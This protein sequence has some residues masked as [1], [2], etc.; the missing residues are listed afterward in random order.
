MTKPRFTASTQGPDTPLAIPGSADGA[1]S[2]TILG[3][4]RSPAD[5]LFLSH[6]GMGEEGMI[7]EYMDF[8][9]D[10]EE[11]EEENG[12]K[13]KGISEEGRDFDIGAVMCSYLVVMLSSFLQVKN[14]GDD[15][16]ENQDMLSMPYHTPKTSDRGLPSP[17]TPPSFSSSD[18]VSNTS[19]LLRRVPPLIFLAEALHLPLMALEQCVR[20]RVSSPALRWHLLQW[21][22]SFSREREDAEC[23]HPFLR[24]RR[25]ECDGARRHPARPAEAGDHR[26]STSI[27]DPSRRE[28][29]EGGNTLYD[30]TTRCEG[31][32]PTPRATST[33]NESS[34]GHRCAS[35]HRH[36]STGTTTMGG[37][38]TLPLP[39]SSTVLAPV[40]IST[41]SRSTAPEPPTCS[42]CTSFVAGQEDDAGEESLWIPTSWVARLEA[43]V[44]YDR[45]H[46]LPTGCGSDGNVWKRTSAVYYPPPLPHDKKKSLQEEEESMERKAP[47]QNG[48]EGRPTT[49][50]GAERE[51][52]HRMKG[53]EEG[54]KEGHGSHALHYPPPLHAHDMTLPPQKAG[55]PPH[56]SLMTRPPLGTF[57]SS[58]GP[59]SRTE[60]EGRRRT[61]RRR[62]GPRGAETMVSHNRHEEFH[63]PPASSSD[64]F[65]PATVE[66]EREEEDEYEVGESWGEG[67]P[68]EEIGSMGRSGYGWL[69]ALSRKHFDLLES[70]V[71][72]QFITVLNNPLSN[73]EASSSSSMVSFSGDSRSA[74]WESMGRALG[75]KSGGGA[76]WFSF[77]PFSTTALTTHPHPDPLVSTPRTIASPLRSSSITST[78][79]TTPFPLSP[80]FISSVAT[81]SE[82]GGDGSGL[83]LVAPQHGGDTIGM[84]H[85]VGVRAGVREGGR[86][87]T[88]TRPTWARRMIKMMKH[89]NNGGTPSATPSPSVEG[90][91]GDTFL[92][93]RTQR[94]A[95]TPTSTN[96][97]LP[98]RATTSS[99]SSSPLEVNPS[100]F[101]SS[102]VGGRGEREK[103]TKVAHGKEE[104]DGDTT[105]VAIA[106]GERGNATEERNKKELDPKGAWATSFSTTT[107]TC[108]AEEP[109][110]C[111]MV[112]SLPS[113]SLKT[114]LRAAGSH[115]AGDH[116]EESRDREE[117]EEETPALFSSHTLFTDSVRTS[118]T[119]VTQ[120]YI[121]LVSQAFQA[122]RQV[123][124]SVK[125]CKETTV[126]QREKYRAGD[127]MSYPRG[128]R[129]R[130]DDHL[131]MNHGMKDSHWNRERKDTEEENKK[132]Q[133]EESATRWKEGKR[134]ANGATSQDPLASEGIPLIPP[135]LCSASHE[136]REEVVALRIPAAPPPPVRATHEGVAE[137]SAHPHS[138]PPPSQDSH[139]VSLSLRQEPNG[140]VEE[141]TRAAANGPGRQEERPLATIAMTRPT[142]VAPLRPCTATGSC[143]EHPA[144]PF[145]LP[146]PTSSSSFGSI[147]LPTRFGL[148]HTAIDERLKDLRRWE[149]AVEAALLQHVQQR[150]GDFF[151]ASQQFSDLQQEAKNVLAAVQH[152]M[153]TT[154]L[155]GREWM[156][157]FLRVGYYARRHHHLLLL[158]T[159]LDEVLQVEN[160]IAT[161]ENWVLL[162]EREASELPSVVSS[163]LHLWK[164]GVTFSGTSRSSR[165]CHRG[166]GD[167]LAE[168]NDHT[169]GGK[170][171][172]N[173]HPSTTASVPASMVPCKERSPLSSSVQGRAPG[174]EGK[175]TPQRFSYP[176]RE[177]KKTALPHHG[178]MAP[179]SMTTGTIQKGVVVGMKTGSTTST[180]TAFS[181]L[182]H[183]G[184]TSISETPEAAQQPIDED[185]QEVDACMGIPWERL[186]MSVPSAR[187]RTSSPTT[188]L[189]ALTVPWR[190][191]LTQA[192]AQLI[193]VVMEHVEWEMEHILETMTTTQTK[194]HEKRVD[195]ITDTTTAG[196][197]SDQALYGRHRHGSGLTNSG[198]S[199]RVVQNVSPTRWTHAAFQLDCWTTTVQHWQEKE[200]QKIWTTLANTALEEVLRS[201]EVDDPTAD[202]L[203][204]RFSIASPSS[205][206]TAKEER[207]KAFGFVASLSFPLFL[208]LLTSLVAAL[209]D[210]VST[211]VLQWSSYIVECVGPCIHREDPLPTSDEEE[212][213]SLP[214]GLSSA[215]S[216]C[217]NREEKKKHEGAP[218]GVQGRREANTRKVSEEWCSTM[219]RERGSGSRGVHVKRITSRVGVSA[220][221]EK[222]TI[223]SIVMKHTM[224]FLTSL[225]VEVEGVVAMY[226]NGRQPT[227]GSSVSSSVSSPATSPSAAPTTTTSSSSSSTGRHGHPMRHTSHGTPA[228]ALSATGASGEGPSSPT[229]GAPSSSLRPLRGE[230]LERVARISYKLIVGL[231]QIIKKA[232]DSLRGEDLAALHVPYSPP[233]KPQSSIQQTLP[234]STTSSCSSSLWY[235]AV[236]VGSILQPTLQQL[237]TGDFRSVHHEKM[238]HLHDTL[239]S[240][241]G[242]KPAEEISYASQS[243]VELLCRADEPAYMGFAVVR[244]EPPPLQDAAAS[245]SSSPSSFFSFTRHTP[246]KAPPTKEEE[247]VVDAGRGPRSRRGSRKGWK[248]RKTT[249]GKGLPKEVEEKLE[250][251]EVEAYDEKDREGRP[252]CFLDHLYASSFFT[253]F[254]ASFSSSASFSSHGVASSTDTLEGASWGAVN[255]YRRRGTLRGAGSHHPLTAPYPTSAGMNKEDMELLQGTA[256]QKLYVPLPH[257]L[258]PH[259]CCPY[260]FTRDPVWEQEEVPSAV[261]SSFTPEDGASVASGAAAFPSPAKTDGA[262]PHGGEEVSEREAWRVARR[263]RRW[264]TRTLC[265]APT[266]TTTLLPPPSLLRET[267]RQMESTPGP[268]EHDETGK[269]E[270]EEGKEDDTCTS[271]TSRV[272]PPAATHLT[273]AMKME[274]GRK[275]EWQEVEKVT[276]E[277]RVVTLPL[278]LL[279]DILYAY[280]EY[281]AKYPSLG[282]II[283]PAMVEVIETFMNEMSTLILDARAASLGILPRITPAHL[284]LGAQSFAVLADVVP[285][286]QFRLLRL[287]NLEYYVPSFSHFS[288]SSSYRDSLLWRSAS[289]LFFTDERGR[290]WR[291]YEPPHPEEEEG[292]E[293]K[294]RS[295]GIWKGPRKQEEGGR[296]DKESHGA[297]EEEFPSTICNGKTCASSSSCT[298]LSTSTL[299]AVTPPPPREASICLSYLLD[300]F[301]RVAALCEDRWRD[302]LQLIVRVIRGRLTIPSA[303]QVGADATSGGGGRA[304]ALVSSVSRRSPS[305]PSTT[306]GSVVRAQV[307]NATTTSSRGA[308]TTG[309]SGSRQA[310]HGPGG[311]LVS[312][313]SPSTSTVSS[314][315]TKSMHTTEAVLPLSKRWKE[316]GHS[317]ILHMLKEM[318]NL[319]RLTRPLLCGAL[320]VDMVMAP[321]MGEI[322]RRMREVFR[323]HRVGERHRRTGRPSPPPLASSLKRDVTKSTTVEREEERNEGEREAKQQEETTKEASPSAMKESGLDAAAAP[324]PK[325][326]PTTGTRSVALNA[327]STEMRTEDPR[328][329]EG[330][331]EEEAETEDS[332]PEEEEELQH[333]LMLFKVNAEKLG[334]DVLRCAS[335][336]VSSLDVLHLVLFLLPSSKTGPSRRE[337]GEA[338]QASATPFP[339]ASYLPSFA[340]S[341]RS[342]FSSSPR[343][344]VMLSSCVPPFLHSCF[345]KGGTN[346]DPSFFPHYH[347]EVMRVPSINKERGEEENTTASSKGT[348]TSFLGSSSHLASV[349]WRP[350]EEEEVSKENDHDAV[351]CALFLRPCSTDKEVFQYFLLSSGP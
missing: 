25:E 141:R 214:S 210:V 65:D 232:E 218:G 147:V 186:A 292:E 171:T 119:E 229:R 264:Y 123:D 154:L 228:P 14:G 289:P 174:S 205:T 293:R 75:W 300:H 69:D 96:L 318:A 175:V 167:T 26:R 102:S 176:T 307:V 261:C 237:L 322:G 103:M 182:C 94:V 83:I 80:R 139:T 107:R 38:A 77:H 128:R 220:E 216:S 54:E 311:G 241:N 222:V 88:S 91:I 39:L 302:C 179:P 108:S 132:E 110:V 63:G 99:T 305:L 105:P 296:A 320:E 254:L 196:R 184:N 314:R 118:F 235:R 59:A 6:V 136:C 180:T 266:T 262:R 43:A 24:F 253:S 100:L 285:L 351:T 189:L 135:A 288:T 330:K 312:S 194:H 341:L 188:S 278:L 151:E 68:G 226:L 61:M 306:A 60:E 23:H 225:V 193:A 7:N 345:T 4:K 97:P 248:V 297:A 159:L 321:L 331:E 158:Q 121:R 255:Y 213:H 273:D 50:T 53:G 343:M 90:W 9:F 84:P 49:P 272:T 162:P 267:R 279:V 86:P 170:G 17:L 251:T 335:C 47:Q 76:S 87:C 165:S 16:L 31:S 138:G 64:S 329:G 347:V 120:S 22:H 275:E 116:E 215:S 271:R 303:L 287:L 323:Q 143:G 1:C 252:F 187:G 295:G 247:R 85:P 72:Q 35:H 29:E 346:D 197:D 281:L 137:H 217:V 134:M 74:L 245:V 5:G 10:I 115:S 51:D 148:F 211:S 286:L 55:I 144:P 66:E 125:S 124:R 207:G 284:S 294:Y 127:A 52:E 153:H 177:G 348:I 163:L 206:S 339:S 98:S 155:D 338:T 32:P 178:E 231:Q 200:V 161:I 185:E 28:R 12:T 45:Q 265:G 291:L 230:E 48:K 221:E 160:A 19:T 27:A 280:N 244:I 309:T 37:E 169:R 157:G 282:Y 240:A 81:T 34:G 227:G 257:A 325:V 250:T 317:W 62:G 333:D 319:L 150:S 104:E 195:T 328:M 209:E 57:V 199:H 126:G 242:W 44:A 258:Y 42:T 204:H 269:E 301:T 89:S 46:R 212:E 58:S 315:P 113:L 166:S 130:H 246:P 298:S 313:L 342:A 202:D 260:P 208:R 164:K 112:A 239:F 117:E 249:Q 181:P 324:N 259:F 156:D 149:E 15:L 316:V 146:L 11:E 56:A 172:W 203:I 276:M 8:F 263:L 73:S 238:L 71:G 101:L 219:R 310:T 2:C 152:T 234:P 21:L 20:R 122:N 236:P 191:R 256:T 40:F 326:T 95:S 223:L 78:I 13:W 277:G 192:R 268:G 274:A 133:E 111:F 30:K 109:G 304:A 18:V 70:A 283:L 198:S 142:G 131:A 327:E 114:A 41:L 336:V 33:M 173:D 67:N 93:P 190:D 340:E 201:G 3:S 145:P 129:R 349:V 344:T 82:D 290:S 168:E 140:N 270:E 243:R 92:F 233:R 308:S 183:E 106:G 332:S 224:A 36:S 79:P 337:E 350:K 334:Y 299:R